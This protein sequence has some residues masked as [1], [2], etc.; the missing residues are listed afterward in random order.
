MEEILL[1][2][3]QSRWKMECI[4]EMHAKLFR[5]AQTQSSVKRGG[6]SV[7][8]DKK[9]ATFFRLGNCAVVK[10]TCLIGDIYIYR[11][12]IILQKVI[13]TYK[14]VN[15]SVYTAQTTSFKNALRLH[16]V[17]FSHPL[18]HKQT[19][20]HFLLGVLMQSTVLM[21]HIRVTVLMNMIGA[22]RAS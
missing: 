6:G 10:V 14:F 17:Y 19:L 13:D 20:T 2:I 11:E 22:G 8:K 5:Q 4:T 7:R 1:M 12:R 16:F 3:F 9:R 15:L 18:L 21:L